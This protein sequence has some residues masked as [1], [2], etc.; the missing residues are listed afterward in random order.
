MGR[1][2]LER[3]IARRR[4]VEQ[5]EAERV[6]AVGPLPPRPRGLDPLA[7]VRVVALGELGLAVGD[8]RLL[9]GRP[10]GVGG[11]RRVEH[12]PARPARAG[13]EAREA[14][15]Q[16]VRARAERRQVARA[17]RVAPEA[18]GHEA[19]PA[20]ARERAE[21][22]ERR[23]PAADRVRRGE[24]ADQVVGPELERDVGEVR[25]VQDVDVLAGLERPA[26]RRLDALGARAVARLDA[27]E[28]LPGAAADVEHRAPSAG[29]RV[30]RGVDRRLAQRVGERDATV[31]DRGDGRAV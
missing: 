29:Q 21:A 25:L 8:Q 1:R 10:V 31:R 18:L 13:L 3:L 28:Q 30:D 9:V 19:E 14:V 4:S 11:D 17:G 2:T 23:L 7:Q 24:A 5:R 12:L 15:R 27:R 16:L 20:A 26:A 22:A 6:L